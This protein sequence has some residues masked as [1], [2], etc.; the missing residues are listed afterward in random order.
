MR[1]HVRRKIALA[2]T[3]ALVISL[4]PAIAVAAPSVRVTRPVAAVAA[5]RAHQLRPLATLPLAADDNIPGVAITPSPIAGTLNATSDMDDVFAVTLAA[6]DTLVASISGPVYT[7]FDLFLFGPGTPALSDTPLASSDSLDRDFFYPLTLQF[8]VDTA[9]GHAP[10]TYYLDAF[11]GVGAGSYTITWRI[12]P[13][14]ADD[15]IP[16]VP[17]PASPYT[18]WNSAGAVISADGNDAAPIDMYDVVAVPLTEGDHFSVSAAKAAGSTLSLE[19][20]LYP[21]AASH[22]DTDGLVMLDDAWVAATNLDTAAMPE[23][24]DFVV[25]PGGAGTYYLDVEA[26]EGVGDYT[27]TWKVDKASVVRLSGGSRFD[28]SQAIVRSTADGSPVAILANGYGYADALAASGLA[29]AYDA[30]LLLTDKDYIPDSVMVHLVAMGV[31]DVKLVGGTSVISSTV[32]E[33][34]SL[35]GFN[36][37]RIAGADRYAT[38]KACADRVLAVKGSVPGAFV[39]RGDAFADALAVSPAAYTQGMPVLLTTPTRL[40]APAAAFLESNDVTQVVVA[41]GTSAVSSGVATALTALNGGTTVVTRQAGANRY[42]T[43]RMVAEY[44]VARGWNTWSFVGVATGT[45]FPD[46]LAGGIG[47]GRMGGVLLLTDP[48]ALSAD[49]KNALV[50]NVA[51]VDRVAVFGGTGAVSAAVFGEIDAIVP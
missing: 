49:C 44:S 37:E 38:S 45:N 2:L 41:G 14:D 26:W 15:D 23:S 10:G 12:V 51:S 11:G 19:L 27:V 43:A 33:S 34:L 5:P 28:T 4:V 13:D 18:R 24:L 1:M 9:L 8:K 40:A 35:A 17:I 30:P 6:G 46:A 47:A 36:V 16:G 20:F 42:A 29:G 48:K 50:A 25:P 22:V 7:Y 39:V 3:L 31:T 21:P 32:A